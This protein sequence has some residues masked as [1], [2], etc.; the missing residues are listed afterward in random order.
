MLFLLWIRHVIFFRLML[1]DVGRAS[2][3]EAVG[4]EAISWVNTQVFVG[5][6]ALLALTVP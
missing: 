6:N 3:G 5:E 2:E 4:F 1:R